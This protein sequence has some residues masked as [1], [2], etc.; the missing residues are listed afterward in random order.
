[1]KNKLWTFGCSFTESLKSMYEQDLKNGQASTF[2]D[3]YKYM[4][5][6]FPP[7]W[8]ELLAEKLNLELENKELV[9]RVIILYFHRLFK[10]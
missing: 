2:I 9:V 5:N 4:G 6:S 1:M 3:Y 8:S 10:T 7:M